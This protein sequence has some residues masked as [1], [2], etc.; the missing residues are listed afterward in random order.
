MSDPD[1]SN[2]I[3]SER[4]RRRV[5]EAEAAAPP[6]PKI[7]LSP[8]QQKEVDKIKEGMKGVVKNFLGDPQAALET[9]RKAL[10][11]LQ[12]DG[13]AANWSDMIS[14]IRQ[15]F[16]MTMHK[17]PEGE[18]RVY[19]DRALRDLVEKFGEETIKQVLI[20]E[21]RFYIEI[22]TLI[23]NPPKQIRTYKEATRAYRRAIFIDAPWGKKTEAEKA[24]WLKDTEDAF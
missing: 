6:R 17:T 18:Q 15:N 11:N 21:F 12:R 19:I 16:H 13:L 1:E 20:E 22:K 7:Q 24:K 9:I 8:E 14:A 3:M 23:T 4:I 10:V 5:Q 2:L